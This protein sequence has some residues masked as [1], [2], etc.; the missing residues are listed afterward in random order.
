MSVSEKVFW[1][2]I[3]KDALG[4][5]FRRQHRID[6]YYLDFYAPEVRL[7]V[8][9]DGEQH[10]ERREADAT[11]DAFL[12]ERGILTIRIPSL[13]LFDKESDLYTDWIYR[14]RKIVEERKA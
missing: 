3:R 14:I 7:C 6:S 11:R 1:I 9:I 5:R 12:A 4:V 10:A 13:D 2:A 8:E